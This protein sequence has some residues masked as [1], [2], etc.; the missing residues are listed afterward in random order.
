MCKTLKWLIGSIVLTVFLGGC[1]GNNALTI[2]KKPYSEKEQALI[3]KT[4]GVE[5]ERF[6]LKGNIKKTQKVEVT[7]EQYDKGKRI[8][9]EP[10]TSMDS[11][12][13]YEGELTFSIMTAEDNGKNHAIIA[14]PSLQVGL[15]IDMNEKKAS[16]HGYLLDEKQ[17][18][19]LKKPVYVAFWVSNNTDSIK[20]FGDMKDFDAK[21]YDTTILLKLE[22]KEK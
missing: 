8:T 4:G 7:L 1:A 20:G 16:G 22:L 10:F 5:G 11:E 19:T 14:L 12:F 18:L 15:D 2:T 3:T 21:A 17:S 6:H 9:S 13:G